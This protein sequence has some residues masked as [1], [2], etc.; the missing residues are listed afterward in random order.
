MI[1]NRKDFSH[2]MLCG[3]KISDNKTNLGVLKFVYFH[4]G[5]NVRNIKT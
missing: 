1:L 2:F 3:M 5:A 4:G